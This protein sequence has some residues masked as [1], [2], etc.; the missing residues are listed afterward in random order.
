MVAIIKAL[1]GGGLQHITPSDSFP[2]KAELFTP[3]SIAKT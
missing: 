2:E 1:N 3:V